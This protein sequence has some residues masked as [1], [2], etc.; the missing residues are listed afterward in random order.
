MYY[1]AL[2]E[3]NY[4]G[5]KDKGDT[6]SVWFSLGWSVVGWF[7]RGS[8][9]ICHFHG[10]T[11]WIFKRYNLLHHKKLNVAGESKEFCQSFC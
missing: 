3:R 7:F 2:W 5:N 4:S 1:N 8:K 11:T 10:S 9:V 6:L